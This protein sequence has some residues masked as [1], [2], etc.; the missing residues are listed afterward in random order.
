MRSSMAISSTEGN[1]F[2]GKKTNKRMD[3]VVS[4]SPG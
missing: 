2:A 3:G 4:N 1:E